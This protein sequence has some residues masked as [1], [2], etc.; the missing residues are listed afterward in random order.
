MEK[1]AC[2]I[3]HIF[4]RDEFPSSDY[5]LKVYHSDVKVI[6]PACQGVAHHD[7]FQRSAVFE[8][9]EKSKARLREVCRNS[10]FWI[11]SQF[12][13]T[14]HET[15]PSTGKESK[16]HLHSFLVKLQRHPGIAYLGDALRYLW[17]LE[18]QGRKA[19]H[20]H[21]FTDL[22]ADAEWPGVPFVVPIDKDELSRLWVLDAQN[23][24]LPGASATLA[25]H[26]HEKNFFP[27]RMVSG[28]YL[29][30]E[31]VEKS[32]QKDVP[33]GFQNVGR[34]WG[35]S[36]NMKPQFYIVE[37]DRVED[38]NIS[39]QIRR[40]IRIITKRRD[41]ESDD[42]ARFVKDVLD[43]KL[44]ETIADIKTN[45]FANEK[46]SSEDRKKAVDSLKQRATNI[47]KRCRRKANRRSKVRSYTLILA[48]ALLFQY[49]DCIN[50]VGRFVDQIKIPF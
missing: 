3:S 11:R 48:S 40:A 47:Q 33:E 9:S 31:Y 27:W 42:K 29:V 25:F 23:L 46:I 30:K 44:S 39:G 49:L 12:C 18:F 26:S 5:F 38:Q 17:V 16:A 43:A 6:K 2:S 36:R 14:Y 10:G 15:W 34:F 37:P 13:L 28:S 4:H 20:Y 19:P 35:N 1:P 22:V 50:Q 32:L 7:K 8:F 24:H 45:G 21:L 41:K